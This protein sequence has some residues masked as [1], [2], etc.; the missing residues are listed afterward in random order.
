[1]NLDFELMHELRGAPC[2]FGFG[3][4]GY[5]MPAQIADKEDDEHEFST[6]DEI[7]SVIDG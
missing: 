5:R 6:E 1:M 7:S 3:R 4:S 2:R